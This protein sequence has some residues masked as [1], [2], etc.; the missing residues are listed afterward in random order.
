[1]MRRMLA[2]LLVGAMFL[3]TGSTRAQEKPKL[4]ETPWYPL[5]V[6]NKWVYQ[7]DEGKKKCEFRVAAHEDF[8]GVLCARVELLID[9]RVASTEHISVTSAGVFRNGYAGAKPD[10]PIQ[11]L[12]LPPTAGDAWDVDSRALGTETV[13]GKFNVAAEAVKVGGTSYDKAIKVTGKDMDANGLKF[14]TT[15]YFAE[16]V[17]IVKQIIE[18]GET[19]KQTTILELEKFEPV[20][21]AEEKKDK[22]K[23]NKDKDNKDK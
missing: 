3:A 11:I 20:K 15:Y 14:S 7:Y 10:K 8:G 16:N 1:M 23:D 22:D 13:K 17:G 6:G 2:V 4:V 9:G 5:A 12:K 21:K 18:V 19:T